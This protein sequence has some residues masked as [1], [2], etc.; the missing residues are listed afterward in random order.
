MKDC[1][2]RNYNKYDWLILY[3]LDEFI[4]LSNYTNIKSFLKKSKFENCQIICLNLIYHTNNNKLYYENKSL[5]E[6]FPKIVPIT[7]HE[8]KFLGV[9]SI[10][11]Y[12]ISN[13]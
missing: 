13:P 6:R 2:R 11:R 8:G 10:I 3:E 12:N 5:S 7:K 9:K 1:Y 4:H